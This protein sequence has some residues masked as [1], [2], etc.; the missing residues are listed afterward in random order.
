MILFFCIVYC[1]AAGCALFCFLSRGL[2]RWCGILT[3]LT[4]FLS[5]FF[6]FTATCQYTTVFSSR[7]R[8]IV[9]IIDDIFSF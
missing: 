5:F 2:S 7:V 3:N 1:A 6:F 4:K 8:K 9:L